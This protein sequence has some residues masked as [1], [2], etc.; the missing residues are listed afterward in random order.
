MIGHL[1]N[2]KG[3]VVASPTLL[4][5]RMSDLAAQKGRLGVIECRTLPC[6]QD[7]IGDS[8]EESGLTSTTPSP[9]HSMPLD[10][11]WRG[12]EMVG[13]INYA[14]PC[15]SSV[16]FLSVGTEVESIGAGGA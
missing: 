9:D 13:A 2:R 3:S 7:K 8:T 12:T 11:V 5:Q 14:P 6:Y 10:V 16:P 1:G 15:P 4:C